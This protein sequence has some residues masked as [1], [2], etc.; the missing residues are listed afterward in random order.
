MS[1]EY[2]ITFNSTNI[3]IKAEQLLL[4]RGL[5]VGVLPLP[6]QISAGCGISLRITP[7]EI[8]TAINILTDNNINDI[9]LFSRKNIS[10]HWVFRDATHL[11][12][13]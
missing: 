9:G 13:G 11:D 12:R 6:P 3:A 7:G 2:I 1:V 10:G 4:A 8:D 5:H